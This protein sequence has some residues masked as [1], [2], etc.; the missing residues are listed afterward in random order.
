V[1]NDDDIDGHDDA[2]LPD[3]PAADDDGQPDPPDHHSDDCDDDGDEG[4]V[5]EVTCEACGLAYECA[6]E[7]ECECGDGFTRHCRLCCPEETTPLDSQHDVYRQEQQAGDPLR[8]QPD[9]RERGYYYHDPEETGSPP[10]PQPEATQL[11][12]TD[13]MQL[14]TQP[15]ATQLEPADD[16][17]LEARRASPPHHTTPH[18]TAPHHTTPHRTITHH[19]T[20]H[21]TTPPTAERRACDGTH[22]LDHLHRLQA[23]PRS[24][25]P[26]PSGADTDGAP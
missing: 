18:R 20:P 19:T 25:S 5:L 15:E 3:A 26:A 16:M 6:H 17:Q 14:E 12:P 13:D 11:E 21:H 24:A 4:P 1:L 22:T 2:D 23:S 7:A 10:E 9:T 8:P